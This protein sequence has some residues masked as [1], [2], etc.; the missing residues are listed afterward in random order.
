[1]IGIEPYRADVPDLRRAIAYPPHHL[2]KRLRVFCGLL[3]IERADMVLHRSV[4]FGN[5]FAH[6]PIVPAR[7]RE[8]SRN[9]KIVTVPIL[10]P[11]SPALVYS[12]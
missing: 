10:P 11:Y 1:M 2:D 7:A 12:A 9:R 3:V 5:L 4:A 8:W 6:R